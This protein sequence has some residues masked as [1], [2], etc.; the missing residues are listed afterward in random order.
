M[1]KMSFDVEFLREWQPIRALRLLGHRWDTILSPED[2]I[3]RQSL[4]ALDFRKV[5]VWN[6]SGGRKIARILYY[7]VLL[8]IIIN[9]RISVNIN[10]EISDF[11]VEYWSKISELLVNQPKLIPT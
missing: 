8:I 11:Y 5:I 2:P 4:L 1:Y 7:M 3:F 6:M 10:Y 9:T